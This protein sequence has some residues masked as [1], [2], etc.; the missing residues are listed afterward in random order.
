GLNVLML[1]LEGTI[2]GIRFN[3]YGYYYSNENGTVQL[4]T[5]T[6]DNLFEDYTEEIETFLSGLA[7]Y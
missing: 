6:S 5:Y 3:Y 2:E 7:E 1:Q 4:I